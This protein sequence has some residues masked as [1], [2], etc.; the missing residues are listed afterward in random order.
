MA[1]LAPDIFPEGDC[2]LN[3]TRF[4]CSADQRRQQLEILDESGDDVEECR[5]MEGESEETL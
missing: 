3:V 5:L 4:G 1:R 2:G